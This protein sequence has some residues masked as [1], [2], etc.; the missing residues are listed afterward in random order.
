[1]DKGCRYCGVNATG[2]PTDDPCVS[3]LSTNL[4]DLFGNHIAR[5]PGRGNA[6]SLIKEVLQYS[7][8]LLGVLYLWVPLH[9]EDSLLNVLK[10]CH[11]CG[12][13]RSQ[14][15]KAIWCLNHLVP[16]AHPAN[17]NIWLTRQQNSSVGKSQIGCPVF[18]LAGL[19][20]LAAKCLSK[21]LKAVANAQYW[22][23]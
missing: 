6:C 14:D 17:L 7:L 12:F 23:S 22:N 21:N 10:S 19:V 18:A 8:A 2:E 13:S 11:R 1:M 16:M 3:N 15:A 4:F 9:A 5:V 20:D